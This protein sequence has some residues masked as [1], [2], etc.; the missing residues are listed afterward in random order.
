MSGSSEEHEA[1][2]ETVASSRRTWSRRSSATTT[3]GTPSRTR[4]SGRWARWACSACRSRRSTAGWAATTSPSASPSRNWPG[5][6]RRWRSP[7]RRASRSARCRSTGSVPR[8]RSANG[9]RGCAPGEALGAFGLTE[10]GFGSDA[11]GTATRAVLDGDEWVINGTKAFITNSGTDITA[12]VTVTA[13]TGDETGRRQGDLGDH[14]PVGYARVHRRNPDTPRS[15]GAPRTPTSCLRRRPGPRGQPAR[16]ARPGLRPVPA[17]PRRGPGRDRGARRSG[18]PR[19]ASTSRSSTPG[20]R[21][22]FGRPIGD[23]QAIQFK[24]A[25]METAGAHRE[26][27]VLRRGGPD[28]WPARSSSAQAAMAK[29]YASEVAVTNA[30]E[31]T[32]I[33]GG[34]GFMNEYPVAR[35]WRDSKILEIGEGTVRGPAHGHRPRPGHVTAVRRPGGTGRRA[36]I[37]TVRNPRLLRR[38]RDQHR[39][40]P[41]VRS[42]DMGSDHEAVPPNDG[43]AAVLRAHRR[44]AGLTQQELAARAGVG[45]RTVRELERGRA[46][47]PQRGTVELLADALGLVAPA[48]TRFVNA[49]RGRSSRGGD[50]PAGR[51]AAYRRA[52]AAVAPRRPGQRPARC[53]R[54]GRRQ[55]RR[56]AHR[57][58]RGRQDMPGTGRGAPAGRPVPGRRGR[59]RRGGRRFTRRHPG[60]HG[61]RTAVC[62]APPTCPSAVPWRRRCSW[63]TGPTGRPG[64]P[65]RR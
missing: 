29:L 5:S 38:N 53:G 40:P 64:R 57:S 4:S 58:G 27:G 45:V 11:G 48:R 43:F 59:G 24:I 20:E 28:G 46:T 12:L 63:S 13:V 51:L 61:D 23:Y 60:R 14:R 56:A 6:T 47:R 15:A 37:P 36:L 41:C 42:V 49:A 44:S 21:H 65:R 1:L 9:C 62:R 32:Q 3:S 39:L 19:A 16:R 52:A 55:R 50:R 2:R 8:R 10:P 25:D 31:A 54:T 30:R 7:W 26:P 22:A 34:Y 17:D 18:W 35:F 33:H